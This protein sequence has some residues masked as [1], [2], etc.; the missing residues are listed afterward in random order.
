MIEGGRLSNWQEIETHMAK[1]LE[2]D[3]TGLEQIGVGLRGLSLY[4]ASGCDRS[5]GRVMA[6]NVAGRIGLEDVEQPRT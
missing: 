1:A 6:Y 2:N 5:S 4:G 3:Q